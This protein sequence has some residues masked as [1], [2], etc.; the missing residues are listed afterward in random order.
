MLLLAGGQSDMLFM[1]YVIFL[2]PL[3]NNSLNAIKVINCSV[4][5]HSKSGASEG[6][7]LIILKPN[8]CN[9]GNANGSSAALIMRRC[10]Y[11]EL[12]IFNMY[13]FI[14]CLVRGAG[15][16]CEQGQRIYT[17]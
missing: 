7:A 5:N 6:F 13:I 15:G 9:F 4:I 8:T 10:Y 16:G 17:E 3:R 11:C 1:S 12:I 2:Q 14:N